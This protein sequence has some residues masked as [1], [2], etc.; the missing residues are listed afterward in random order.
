MAIGSPNLTPEQLADAEKHD[1][2]PVAKTEL[3]AEHIGVK[4]QKGAKQKE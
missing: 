1:K 4:A 2:P 3:Q